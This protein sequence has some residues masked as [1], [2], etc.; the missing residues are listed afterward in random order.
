MNITIFGLGYVGLVAAICFAEAGNNVVCVDTD[1][2]KIRRLQAGEIPIYEPGLRDLLISLL[3]SGRLLFTTDQKYAVTHGEY[4]FIAVGTP[5]DESGKACLEYVYQVARS[6]GEH[7]TLPIIVVNKSTVPIGTAGTVE[8]IIRENLTNRKVDIPFEVVSNP[9]FLREGAAIV[10][11]KNPDR[12]IVGTKCEITSEKMRE[13]Y[14]PFVSETNSFLVMDRVSAELTKYAA[15]AMLATKISFMNE[16]A[17]LSEKVGADIE[18]VRKGIA[19]DPR[20]GPHFIYS[21]CG[22]GGSCFGKDIKALIHTAREN[23]CSADI[24]QAVEAVNHR[25][26][27]HLISK[28]NRHYEGKL[29]NKNFAIWGLAFKPQTNDMR[30]APSLVIIEALLAQGASCQVSDP[31]ALEEAKKYLPKGAKIHYVDNMYH[32]L[33]GADALV[34][35]TQWPVYCHPDFNR[36]ADSMNAK[37]IFDGRNIYDPV[38]L[39]N[40]GFTYY[41]IGR[42]QNRI[43][44]REELLCEG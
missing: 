37:V 16:M 44:A 12:I 32:V 25:Q 19:L 36:M 1:V 14:A 20:I 43:F 30:D 28:I 38:L 7:M 8:K 33:D 31:A 9:E 21:G 23:N 41:G 42:R 2:E 15:N 24:I 11:F 39:E 13:L 4:Q 26:K 17:L 5:S 22:Y 10:D 27:G 18:N 29:A 34:V 3:P 40:L 6:I 35:L